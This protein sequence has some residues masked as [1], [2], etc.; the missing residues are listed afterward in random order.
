[1]VQ[2]SEGSQLLHRI[3]SIRNVKAKSALKNALMHEGEN[4]I[5]TFTQAGNWKSRISIRIPGSTWTTNV[6]K[7][8]N[9]DLD[10]HKDENEVATIT[11]DHSVMQYRKRKICMF[12]AV[13]QQVEALICLI[14][15]FSISHFGRLS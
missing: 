11:Y 15:V 4:L 8:R 6:S 5:G 13:N 2:L 10:V 12:E 9:P 1:L 14:G 3:K 7:K